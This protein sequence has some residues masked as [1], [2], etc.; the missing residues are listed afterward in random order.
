VISKWPFDTKREKLS[1][2]QILH[3]IY[4]GRVQGQ[5][6][7]YIFLSVS[8]FEES[9]KNICTFLVNDTFSEILIRYSKTDALFNA[10][11]GQLKITITW[12]WKN[13]DHTNQ[14]NFFFLRPKC[15]SHQKKGFDSMATGLAPEFRASRGQLRNNKSVPDHVTRCL[16]FWKYVAI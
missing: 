9:A 5:F 15:C 1:R 11:F 6:Y 3:L 7:N 13:G 2:I 10:V 8:A 16:S 14:N 12:F 4:P